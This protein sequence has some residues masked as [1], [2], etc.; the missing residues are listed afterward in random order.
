MS[1]PSERREYPRDEVKWP[2]TLITPEAQIEGEIENFTPK[3][4]FVSCAEVLPSEGILRLVIK[5][6]GRQTM[7]VAGKVIWSTIIDTTES[8]A[9]LGVGIQFT[10][11]S[12]SDLQVLH[13]V[14]TEYHRDEER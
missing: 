11:I 9:R 3:G 14:A 7:N 12:K 8:G 2:V 10:E 4:L 6:P 13:E 5:V 1:E